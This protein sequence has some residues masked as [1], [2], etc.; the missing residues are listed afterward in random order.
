MLLE[1]KL[2]FTVK[3]QCF[4]LSMCRANYHFLHPGGLKSCFSKILERFSETQVKR[5]WR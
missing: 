1:A 3:H 4:E 5:M 2:I